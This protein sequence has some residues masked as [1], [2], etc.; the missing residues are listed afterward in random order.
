MKFPT[1]V[2]KYVNQPI[3]FAAISNYSTEIRAAP[4]FQVTVSSLLNSNVVK[5]AVSMS[6]RG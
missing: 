2:P 6:K 4:R 3:T 1:Y 5:D